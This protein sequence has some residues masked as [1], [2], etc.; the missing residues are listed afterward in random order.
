VAASAGTHAGGGVVDLVPASNPNVGALRA[1]GFAA[2]NR[3]AAWGSPSFSPHIH[4]VALG[5][6][7]VSPGAANQVM[8]Y[9]AG[10]N[11]L[12]DGGPD[13]YGGGIPSVDGVS[14]PGGGRNV[15]PA[16]LEQNV[17]SFDRGGY[18]QPGYT[19]AFNGTGRPEPVGHHLEP[20]GS[21]GVE[22]SMPIT[23]NGNANAQEVVD[24]I[25]SQVL[26]KL[27]QYLSKGTGNN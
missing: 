22:I 25:N 13:N 9:L 1:V 27:R 14:A 18:L 23:I 3:G 19:M 6:P 12:A 4:A 5:D 17:V 2:W 8:S 11:G 7:T 20:K 24:G 16:D 21:R 10:G 15:D 26:P